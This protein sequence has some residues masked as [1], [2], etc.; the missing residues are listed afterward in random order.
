MSWQSVYAWQKCYAERAGWTSSRKRPAAA[1]Q[2]GPARGGRRGADLRA[3]PQEP[4]SGACRISF[5]LGLRGLEAAPSQA[6][7]HRVLSRNG[8]VI[9]QEQEYRRWPYDAPMQ[10]SQSHHLGRSADL[11]ILLTSRQDL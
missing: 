4:R 9:T 8:L 2:P 3:A 6:T 1:F 5:E 7:V 10:L 11:Q